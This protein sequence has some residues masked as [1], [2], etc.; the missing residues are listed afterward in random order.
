MKKT[1]KATTAKKVVRKVNCEE[2]GKQ[3]EALRA[4]LRDLNA[5]FQ[6][7]MMGLEETIEKLEKNQKP[8]EKKIP[9]A[10]VFN[11][12]GHYIRTY[13]M[14]LHGDKYKDLAKM[15]ATK[16]GGTVK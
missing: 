12:D 4:E 8:I 6:G 16:I 11:K 5:Q 3:N 7:E 1:K 15:Y 2:L 9:S 14:D 13:D 10:D